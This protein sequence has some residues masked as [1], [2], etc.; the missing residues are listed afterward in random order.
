MQRRRLALFTRRSGIASDGLGR[1]LYS[2]PERGR[3]EGSRWY[4]AGT[5][6][7]SA[8]LFTHYLSGWGKQ[9]SLEEPKNL[10]RA[11]HLGGGRAGTQGNQVNAIKRRQ[12]GVARGWRDRAKSHL[13]VGR[14]RDRNPC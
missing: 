4:G 1:V 5:V 10:S 11:L 9:P 2:E 3:K 14:R 12:K 8:K 7:L 13:L 6:L